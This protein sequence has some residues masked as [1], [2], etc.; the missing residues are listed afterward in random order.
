MR[1]SATWQRQEGDGGCQLPRTS[2]GWN[3]L[4]S[5]EKVY[6][7]FDGVI[8]ARNTDIGALIDAGAG[9]AGQGAV[10][11]GGHR[12]T[13]R[14]RR[15][16]RSLFERGRNR[17]AATLTLDEYPGPR[18]SPARWCATPARSIPRRARCWSKWTWTIRPARCFP[19]LTFR[20]PEAA[21]TD[22]SG[23]HPV[24]HVAVPPGRAARRRG[25][26]R[27]ARCSFPSPSAATTA[28]T[29]EVVSGLQPR[30]PVILDPA[31]FADRG[32]AGSRGQPEAGSE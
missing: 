25:S 32:D 24:E 18:L 13:A 7:P 2:A 5:Y 17:R 29:V 1:R 22:R 9:R 27:A 10:P 15:R 20:P 19:A 30:D 14:V 28:T 26:R 31:G 11:P 21:G 23:H 8:T 3:N 6:A 4:Q 12:H 16:A